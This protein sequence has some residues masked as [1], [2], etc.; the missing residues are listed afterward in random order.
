MESNSK[1]K[2]KFIKKIFIV[3]IVTTLFGII[4]YGCGMYERAQAS[5]NQRERITDILVGDDSQIPDDAP[6]ITGT[7]LNNKGSEIIQTKEEYLLKYSS[8]SETD[9]VGWSTALQEVTSIVKYNLTDEDRLIF[10]DDYIRWTYQ[11]DVDSSKTEDTK[12]SLA[13][14]NR[15][16]CLDLIDKFF[17]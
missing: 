15:R 16:K 14:A 5:T 7:V 6:I 11:R 13:T 2:N 8:L 1:T 10:A 17:K 4:N 3:G 12:V 9:L